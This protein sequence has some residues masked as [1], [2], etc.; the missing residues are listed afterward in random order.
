M[1]KLM[2]ILRNINLI[3]FK[4]RQFVMTWKISSDHCLVF[5]MYIFKNKIN[6]VVKKR[7]IVLVY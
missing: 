1:I 5:I 3:A 2:V 6:F 4:Y 7:K